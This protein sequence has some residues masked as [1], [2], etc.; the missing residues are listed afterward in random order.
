MDPPDQHSEATASFDAAVRSCFEQFSS[1]HPSDEEWFQASLPTSLGGLGLRSLAKHAPAAFL[2]SRSSCYQ[3][4]QDLDPSHTFVSPVSGLRSPEAL[5][6][7]TFNSIVHDRDRID[8]DHSAGLSRKT[9]SA[10]IDSR[11]SAELRGRATLAHR[12]HLNFISAEGAGLWL[13]ATPSAVAGLNN[14]PAIYV[15]MLRRW[16]RV[17]FAS[18]DSICPSCEGWLDSFGDHALTCCCGGDRTRRHNLI[19][20]AAYHAAAAA[21]LDPELEKPGLLPQR[22]S[23]G[24][25]YDN[26]AS[27]GASDGDASFRRPA[28]VYIPRWQR[29]P[30]AAWDFAVTSGLR[31]ECLSD[32]VQDPA[33]IATRYEDLKCSFKDTRDACQAQGISFVPMVVE[34]TGGGWGKSARCVWS[35]LAK[36]TSL[37][38]GELETESTCAIHFLQRLSMVLHR[39]NARACLRRF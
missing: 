28:D 37:S 14:E 27:T 39:E 4:C 20:N 18:K 22:M 23:A 19:R 26:G 36:S 6:R 33:R 5:A 17:P 35:K 11:S 25:S 30:P 15:A 12:A 2:A 24:S 10:C 31:L 21:R 38:R 7:D 16:L 13:Q 1:L 34:A 9:L 8:Q 3:F 29:G 32:A